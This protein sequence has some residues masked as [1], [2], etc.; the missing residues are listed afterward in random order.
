MRCI[1]LSICEGRETFHLSWV[2]FLFHIA[3]LIYLIYVLPSVSNYQNEQYKWKFPFPQE[4]NFHPQHSVETAFI[5]IRN[6]LLV[7]ESSGYISVK[8]FVLMLST[9]YSHLLDT[10]L[11]LLF[12][13]AMM[14]IFPFIF[15]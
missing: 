11:S 7:A 5:R 3:K 10:L 1:Y 12:L 14:S 6:N 8:L 2:F 4:T 9:T 15:S 13:V